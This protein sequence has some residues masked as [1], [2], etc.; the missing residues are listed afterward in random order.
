MTVTMAM[1]YGGRDELV[2]ATK[3]MLAAAAA[4]ELDPAELDEE[5]FEQ[6]LDTA[7][8]PDPDLII[9]TS[10]EQRLSG[11]MSW[12]QQYSEFYFPQTPFPDFG[13]VEFDEALME[14]EKRKR[15]FGGG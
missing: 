8:M 13:K 14:Y 7:N 6:F 11:F 1:N 15:R 3:K 4:G 9:R 10:G 12:Q 2:R 5:R